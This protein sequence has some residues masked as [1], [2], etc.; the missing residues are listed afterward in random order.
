[1]GRSS[2]RAWGESDMPVRIVEKDD[3]DFLNLCTR[4]LNRVG[5]PSASAEAWRFPVI[6]VFRGTPLDPEDPDNEVIFIY[7]AAPGTVTQV[8]VLGSFATLYEAVPLK[9]IRF[10]GEDSGYFGLSVAV[11]KGQTHIYQYVVDGTLTLDPINPQR[12]VLENGK[13]WSRFFTESY[14]Q[15]MVLESWELKLLYRLTEQILPFRAAEA[16]LFL[17]QFYNYLDR[18]S[19]D[20]SKVYRLDE[21]VG[22]VNAIDKF[23]AREERHRLIDYRRCL[24]QIDTVLRKRNPYV[25]PSELSKEFFNDLYN[26]M[27]NDPSNL[28]NRIDGWDYGVYSNPQFFVYILRRHTVTAAF[29]HPKYGGN[30][31]AAGWAYLSEKYF[32]VKDGQRSTLFDWQAA[33][34]KPL[35]RNAAYL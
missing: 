4:Y 10:L 22:E 1:M 28:A 17:Q 8:G 34:E 5:D 18:Q 32:E 19:K 30:V 7:K 33:L 29:S 16:E 35:G 9:P 25:E 15:P 23:L 11:P 6:D 14:L 26:D 12:V 3:Q 24:K 20:A 31:G 2:C 13:I 21:S 27:S